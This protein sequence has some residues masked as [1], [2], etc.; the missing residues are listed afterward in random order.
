V[1][2][3]PPA[4][5]PEVARQRWLQADRENAQPAAAL[6]E[7][8]PVMILAPVVRRDD[9]ELSATETREQALSDADHLG[10]LHAIWMDQCRAE[11]Y[12][13]YAEAV[14]DY[15][16]PADAQEILKDT[17]RLWRSVRSA[18]LAGLN[19]AAVI[20]AAISGRPFTGARSHSAVLDARIRNVTAGLPPRTG[21]SWAARLPRFAGPELGRYM[22][23]VAAAMDGRLRRIGEH[24]AQERPLWATQAL[25]QVPAGLQQ[26]AGWEARAGR[27]GAYREMSGWDH[28]GEAIG[29]EP[30]PAFRGGPSRMARRVRGH[31]PGGGHRRAPPHRRSAVRPAPGV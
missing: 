30:A 1:I 13:R 12:S 31:G 3:Q 11:A 7:Q 17:G 26:R 9:A 16:E 5:D 4:P 15:A 19:G 29:P 27:L 23:E 14:R 2:G 18:E 10:A 20:R 25:G 6:D 24:A 22:G 21:D 28:P 8:D